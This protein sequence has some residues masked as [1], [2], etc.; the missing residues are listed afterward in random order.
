M[1]RKQ[2]RF[3]FPKG[4]NK[5]HVPV[6]VGFSFPIKEDILN[7]IKK[8]REIMGKSK[9]S[10]ASYLLEISENGEIENSEIIFLKKLSYNQKPTKKTK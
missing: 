9:S 3:K 4:V 6:L 1:K 8:I 5:V 7:E 2:K 10:R